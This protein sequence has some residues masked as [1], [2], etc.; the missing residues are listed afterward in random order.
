MVVTGST[1]VVI[2]IAKEITNERKMN[3]IVMMVRS[4]K[5]SV[6]LITNSSSHS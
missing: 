2:R 6:D 4:T 1:L 5:E 3:E